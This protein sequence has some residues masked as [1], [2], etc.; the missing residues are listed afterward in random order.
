MLAEHIT[1]TEIREKLRTYEQD[2]KEQINTSQKEQKEVFSPP[3]NK[4]LTF[5]QGQWWRRERKTRRTETDIQEWHPGRHAKNHQTGL[6]YPLRLGRSQR[7]EQLQL[8][9]AMGERHALERNCTAKS[10]CPKIR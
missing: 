8:D 10:S 6:L 4:I 1:V 3:P 9:E 7:Q 2:I 5:F